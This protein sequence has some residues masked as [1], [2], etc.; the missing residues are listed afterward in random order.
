MN[1]I[2]SINIEKPY[3][4]LSI[5]IFI[6]WHRWNDL[7]DVFRNSRMYVKNQILTKTL[8]FH[9]DTN[10]MYYNEDRKY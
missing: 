4:F 9:V 1:N 6:F 7:Y 8:F 10:R 3:Y 2:I 5:P